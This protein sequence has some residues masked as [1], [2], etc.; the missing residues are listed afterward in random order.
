MLRVHPVLLHDEVAVLLHRLAVDP[1]HGAPPKLGQ[2]RVVHV[3]RLEVE[4][5]PRADLRRPQRAH[6]LE[7]E[8]P[9]GEQPVAHVLDLRGREQHY[10][11]EVRRLRGI[12]GP[13]MMLYSG[14]GVGIS[15]VDIS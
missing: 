1:A 12:R 15:G 2:R 7:R 4:R 11:C 8:P 10:V 5:E 6:A 14:S 3:P 13:L 9:R